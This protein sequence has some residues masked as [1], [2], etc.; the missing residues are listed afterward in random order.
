MTRQ[1]QRYACRR[2]VSRAWFRRRKTF[3][4]MHKLKCRDCQGVELMT[5]KL[6][7]ENA[8]REIRRAA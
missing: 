4:P 2:F 6:V 1:C 3:R 5:E 7:A 8:V